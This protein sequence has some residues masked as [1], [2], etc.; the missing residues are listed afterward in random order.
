MET[1]TRVVENLIARVDGPL[2]FRIIV[3][4]AMAIIYAIVDGIKDGKSGRTPYLWDFA[5]NPDNRKNLLRSGWD[6]FGKIFILAI[7]LDVVYQWKV[8]H[9]IYP[10]E[11]LFV[12]LVLAAIPYF[13]LRGPVNRLVRLFIKKPSKQV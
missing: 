3:Q 9:H 2:H 4:P 12:A 6:H 13:L 11:T 5:T 8:N 10:V 7:V 1:L